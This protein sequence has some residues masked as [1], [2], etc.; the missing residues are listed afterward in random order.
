MFKVDQER[1]AKFEEGLAE[2][3]SA[4]DAAIA[5]GY[6]ARYA[7]KL[8]SVAEEPTPEALIN[9]AWKQIHN[10]KCPERV[11]QRYWEKLGEHFGLWG[12]KGKPRAPAEAIPPIVEE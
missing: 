7:R 3:L 12:S 11:R 6:C 5:A 2:G 9:L 1:R 4:Y 8:A 10:N